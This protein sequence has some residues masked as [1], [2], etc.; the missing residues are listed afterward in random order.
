MFVEL[1]DSSNNWLDA[2][3]G[4]GVS[5]S[6]TF[7]TP[8]TY[9]ARVSPDY[10]DE[11]TGSAYSLT[12]E[13][14]ATPERDSF[15]VDDS[16]EQ[17]SSIA[18]G[19]VQSRTFHVSVD[20]DWVAIEI[21]EATTLTMST[22]NLSGDLDTTLTLFDSD[23]NEVAYNDDFQDLESQIE[24]T[25]DTPGTYYLLAGPLDIAIPGATYELA[26]IESN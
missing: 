15:E 18:I 2:I 19:E 3:S 9:Y 20:Q 17:A 12:L 22:Q 14:I 16:P 7:D 25:F 4:Y 23:M 11:S 1:Y 8:G 6:Y 13:Q 5:L 21:T 10:I 24:Y 26:V